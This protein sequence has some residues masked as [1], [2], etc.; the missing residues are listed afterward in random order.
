M[1]I[2]LHNEQ[3]NYLYLIEKDAAGGEIGEALQP[4]EDGNEA[5]GEVPQ[6]EE[7]GN[8]DVLVK[9]NRFNFPDT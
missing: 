3:N 2:V 5:V 7:D 1:Y 6:P 4:A 8:G 9:T